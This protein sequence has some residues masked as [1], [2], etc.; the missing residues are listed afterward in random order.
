MDKLQKLLARCKCGIT[1]NID[2]HKNSYETAAAALETLEACGIEIDADV[3]AKI[4][5]TDTLIDLQF[6]PDTPIGFYKV[7]HYS[8]ESALDLALEAIAEGDNNA[9]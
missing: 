3:K 6:Y 5:E 1:I 2:D 4:I 9:I 8:W 7:I